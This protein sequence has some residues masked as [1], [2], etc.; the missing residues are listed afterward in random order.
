[1]RDG[2]G[3]RERV[4]GGS[5]MVDEVGVVGEREA[6]LEVLDTLTGTPVFQD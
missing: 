6:D 1:M 2:V 4:K 5:M 3:V